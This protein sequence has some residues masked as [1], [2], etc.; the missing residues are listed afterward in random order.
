MGQR[1][2]EIE[3]LPG[4]TVVLVY[5]LSFVSGNDLLF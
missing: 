5:R 1:M 3:Y 2:T 4:L